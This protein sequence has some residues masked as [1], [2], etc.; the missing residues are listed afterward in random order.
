[1]RN[2]DKILLV[3]SIILCIKNKIVKLIIMVII[4]RNYCNYVCIH[5]VE[6]ENLES[7]LRS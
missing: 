4:N 1:M 2:F 6:R 5:L 3:F 7:M